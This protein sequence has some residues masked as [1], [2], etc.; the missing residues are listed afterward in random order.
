MA[1]TISAIQFYKGTSN[2][3]PHQVNLWTDTGTLIASADSANESASGW[4]TV[5]L[6]TPVAI[7][8]DTTYVASYHTSGFYSATSGYFTSD[9]TSGNL[10]AGAGGNGVYAYGSDSLFPANSFNST[11]YWVDVVFNPL[12]A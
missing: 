1:G 5:A 4:Q 11:N 6:D 10:V 9:V 12:A 7:S 8:A 3:G 2:V